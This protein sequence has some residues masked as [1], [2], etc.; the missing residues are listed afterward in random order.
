MSAR[1]VM[2]RNGHPTTVGD[3]HFTQH[4]ACS[5]A[6]VHDFFA[7]DREQGIPA[8]ARRAARRYCHACP[9]ITACHQ[10]AVDGD[11]IGLWGGAWHSRRNQTRTHKATPLLNTPVPG[12]AA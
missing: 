6:N 8:R 7:H 1:T 2:A 12:V 5:N 11:E 4:A 9:V 3:L 10:A